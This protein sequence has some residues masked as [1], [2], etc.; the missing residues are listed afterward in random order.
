M[1]RVFVTPDNG[2]SVMY[3]CSATALNSPN[4]SLVWTAAHCL[5][6]GDGSSWYDHWVFV[7]GYGLDGLNS[8]NYGMFPAVRMESYSNFYFDGNV[9][10]DIGAVVVGKSDGVRLLNRIG[11]GNGL[12]TNLPRKSYYKAMGYPGGGDVQKSCEGLPGN[13]SV[14]ADSGWGQPYMMELSCSKLTP[15]ASG[16][17]WLVDLNC[18]ATCPVT[19]YG[20]VASVNSQAASWNGQQLSIYGPYQTSL[21]SMLF[22]MLKSVPV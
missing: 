15:G 16:G 2:S 22:N 9:H 5:S 21:A 11:G 8:H 6:D 14:D 1:G 4:A 7:P 17:P 12:V 10:Y 13:L 3:Y 19:G 18:D 20:W